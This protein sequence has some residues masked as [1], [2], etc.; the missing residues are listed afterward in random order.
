MAKNR[1]KAEEF[2]LQFCK[3]IEPT[4]YNVEQYKK[5]F[6]DMSDKEFD[7]Y[8]V[9]LRDKTKFLVLFKPMY[10]AKGLTTENNLKV[11]T[12]YGLDFFERLQFTGN[13]N[14]PDT[15]TSIKYLVIDL[16]YRRQSQT[17]EKKISLP[18]NNRIIDQSTYQ[19]T[20]A[21]KGAKVSFPELQVLIGM[22]LDNSVNELI[23]FRGGDRGGFSAYN[24]MMLRYG[25]VNLRTLNNYATGVES[26]KTLKS[27]L[28]GMH[29][30]QNL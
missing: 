4:G 7:D 26:T 13:A 21:S 8:M 20:G 2:I 24:S 15:V 18:D 28:L 3:D 5:I 6:A 23:K 9:G 11:A 30:K 1:K 16:P 22:G 19:P 10:K 17:L 12:K 29:I 27:Y 14:E 25:S